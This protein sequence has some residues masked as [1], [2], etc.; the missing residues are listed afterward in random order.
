MRLKIGRTDKDFLSARNTLTQRTFGPECSGSVCMDLSNMKDGDVAGF[1][2]L[3]KKYGLVG[4]KF[5]NGEKKVFM[6][7]VNADVPV[8]IESVPIKQD[9]LKFNT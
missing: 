8:E 3:Q 1:G 6:E 9:K 2:L 7:T 4:V 5:E